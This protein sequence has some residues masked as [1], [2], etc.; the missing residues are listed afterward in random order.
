MTILWQRLDR[1]GH[2]IARLVQGES[3]WVLE[4]TA[5]FEEAGRPCR[6][7][8]RVICDLHWRTRATRLQG[9][10]GGTAIHR[11]M[12]AG[13]ERAWTVNGEPC[14]AVNGCEDVDLSFTPATNLLPIRR[15][16]LEVGQHAHACA[17]W[18]RWP[19]L[20]LEPLAQTYARVAEGA[21][22]YES[23]GGA[24]TA[25]LRTNAAGFVTHYPGLWQCVCDQTRLL[26]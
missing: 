16:R 22:A 23:A 15:L 6:L 9:W 20:T 11:Q 1:A 17:A 7:D 8:Y 25:V 4:G 5:V 19:E 24:F 14:P 13:Q 10:L 26:E 12:A 3:A 21:Y 18:L 2:D